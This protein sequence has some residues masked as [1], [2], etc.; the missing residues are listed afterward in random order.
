MHS[1]KAILTIGHSNRSLADFLKLVQAH[2]VT[3]IAD[4]RKMPRSRTN[5]HFNGDALAKSLAMIGVGYVS[6]LALGGLRRG[7]TDSPNGAWENASFRA[8]ADYMLTPE[9]ETAVQ[10]LIERSQD[11]RAAIMCAEAVPWRCHRS[12][13][14]DA[15]VVRGIPVEHMMTATK[16]TLHTLKSWAHVEGTR[17][18]Y[19]PGPPS[20]Q[21]F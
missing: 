3:L 9:F 12:L 10:D 20:G 21:L 17:I 6:L 19:P 8:F 15:L 2:G 11:Q 16:A 5:P 13:I 14:A 18:T 4:V 7:R 1:P